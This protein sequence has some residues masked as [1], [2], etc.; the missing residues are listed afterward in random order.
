MPFGNE[1]ACHFF[2]KTASITA[3][4]ALLIGGLLCT[5]CIWKV[6]LV[7]AVNLGKEGAQAWTGTGGQ[8]TAPREARGPFL[9]PENHHLAPVGIGHIH[10]PLRRGD[11]E[12]PA[13]APR[14]ETV[15]V[16]Q[17]ALHDLLHLL[18]CRSSGAIAAHDATPAV[19]VDEVI[20]PRQ[21]R[22]RSIVGLLPLVFGDSKQP[23]G[24]L[25]NAFALVEV[26]IHG[27]IA[28]PLLSPGILARRLPG[29][30]DA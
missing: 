13:R 3:K 26:E 23:G 19:H 22:S 18:P 2:K 24:R 25:E 7:R 15:S 12:G 20:A 30:A 5:C 16:R 21:A 14:L 1:T 10:Q 9:R 29:I 6:L 4:H 28:L 8:A 17:R 27:H 11:A